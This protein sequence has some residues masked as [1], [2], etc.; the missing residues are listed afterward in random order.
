MERLDCVVV[1]AGVVGLAVARALA[2]REREVL[3][4]ESNPVIGNETSSR[5][6]E[7]VHAGFLYPPHSLRARFCRPGGGMLVSY[8]RERE[9]KVTMWGKLVLAL[10]DREAEMLP[11][12]VEDGL[13][14]GVDDLEILTGADVGRREPGIHCQAALYSPSTAVVDSH[15]FMLSLQGDAEN[16]GATVAFNTAVAG[17]RIDGSKKTLI[18]TTEN[19][20]RYEIEWNFLVNAAGLG[21]HAVAA[22]FAGP[23][24]SPVPAI[25]YAKGS[26]FTLT[27]KCPFDHIVVPLGPTLTAGG[28]FT[29]DPGGQGKFGPDVEWVREPDYFVAPEKAARFAAAINRYWEGVDAERL[30]PGYAGVRPRSYGE[31]APPGDWIIETEKDHGVPGLINLLGIETPGLTGSMAVA[32]HVADHLLH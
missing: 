4:I 3:I 18:A 20:D 5:N 22:S 28:A 14:C 16:A 7:V 25:H 10:D 27:G 12:F 23:R 26:F 13:S 8:C 2:L 1:G 29:I 21:A 11:S 19:E 32:E 6:N 17:G 24:R 9:I 31:G 15:A 30:Q